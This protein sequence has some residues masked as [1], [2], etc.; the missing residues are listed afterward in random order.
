MFEKIWEAFTGRWGLAALVLLAIPDGRKALKS[1][2][3]EAIRAGLI[4]SDSTKDLIAEVKEEASDMVAEV[5]AE[6]KQNN[7]DKHASE[8]HVSHKS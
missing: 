8:K 7:S 5:K 4:V 2:A 6:R 3:K 1:V